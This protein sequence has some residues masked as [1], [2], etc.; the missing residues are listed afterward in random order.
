[1]E[2]N[3]FLLDKVLPFLKRKNN[4]DKL[5]LFQLYIQ[6]FGIGKT[7]SYNISKY[8][9]VH[10]SFKMIDYIENDLN[11]NT[12][13]IFFSSEKLLDMFLEQNMK[14]TLQNSIDIYNYRGSRYK[15]KL[16]LN[17]QRRRANKKT[18][19]RIR[20]III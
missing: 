2:K 14:R 15:V 11:I 5:N 8:S 13:H 10:F 17:G 16:P 19:K 1:L 12:K 4:L 6:R 20:P 7:I 3:Y 18:A 9:G